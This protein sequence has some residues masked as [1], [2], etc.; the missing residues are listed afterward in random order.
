MKLA[1]YLNRKYPQKMIPVQALYDEIMP[2]SHIER[3]KIKQ[4]VR[5]T[6]KTRHIPDTIV[7]S[8]FVE[9]VGKFV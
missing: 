1:T 3:A 2:E 7:K 4:R 8:A 6:V 9:I 5:S